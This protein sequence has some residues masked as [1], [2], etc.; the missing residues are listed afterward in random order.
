MHYLPLPSDSDEYSVSGKSLFEWRGN[1]YVVFHE[2]KSISGREE[3]MAFHPYKLD[4]TWNLVKVKS[5]GD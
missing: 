4:S 3:T 1:L 5:L 2:F